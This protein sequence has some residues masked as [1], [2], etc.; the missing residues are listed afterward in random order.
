MGKR[1][2]RSALPLEWEQRLSQLRQGIEA[3]L[4]EI[5]TLKGEIG[6]AADDD[7]GPD[8]NDNYHSQDFTTV[9]WDGVTYT[10]TPK[11]A[12]VICF[13]W[14]QWKAGTPWVRQI[15]IAETLGFIEHRFDLRKTFRQLD[16]AT[17]KMVPHDAMGK[18]IFSN[19]KGIFGLR[20]K[21]Q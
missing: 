11:Q 17:K 15:S 9:V 12:D 19:G 7:F 3:L 13:L 1:S 18:M 21:T 6:P 8:S 10:F 14:D 20:S 16:K 5:E 2:P 4:A